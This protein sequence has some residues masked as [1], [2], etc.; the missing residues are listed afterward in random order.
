MAL[1]N[2]KAHKEGTKDTQTAKPIS[3]KRPIGVNWWALR[4]SFVARYATDASLFIPMGL[5]LRLLRN[6]FSH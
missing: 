1:F 5:A 6:F 2:H 4:K 3:F